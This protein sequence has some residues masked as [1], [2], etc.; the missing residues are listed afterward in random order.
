MSF[1]KKKI[2]FRVKFIAKINLLIPLY[3]EYF[4]NYEVLDQGLE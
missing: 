4:V 3:I 1:Y 2:T